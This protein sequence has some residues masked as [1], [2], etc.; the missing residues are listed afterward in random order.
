MEVLASLPLPMVIK[1]GCGLTAG[2]I[3]LCYALAV[4]L[5]HVPAWLPM[6]SDCAVQAPERY[7]FRM[8]LSLGAFLL[9]LEVVGVYNSDRVFS[10]NKFC[11]YM[12]CIASFG[13][14]VVGVVNEKE[15]N[16][17]HVGEYHC[18]FPLPSLSV[19]PLMEMYVWPAVFTHHCPPP[20]P[21]QLVQVP[22][23]PSML[24]TWW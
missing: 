24:C 4:G 17:V 6:I 18:L 5:G 8:G 22:S 11:L 1:S 7:F 21:P 13:L 16:T 3:L 23:L 10:K 14:G 12:G 15:D 2:T 20:S 9:G 19:A